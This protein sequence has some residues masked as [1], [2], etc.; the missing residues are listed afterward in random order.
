MNTQVKFTSLKTNKFIQF[1]VYSNLWISIGAALLCWQVFHLN[2]LEFNLDYFLFV[3]FSTLVS[4]TVQRLFRINKIAEFNPS[5]WVVKNKKIAITLT[6]VGLIG[7]SISLIQFIS[8]PV[9]LWLIPSGIIS[10]LYS[11][12]KLRDVPY[13]KIFLISISWGIICG[14][15]PFIIAENLDFKIILFN[16]LIIM[17]YITA[18]TIPF[19]IRDL[20]LDE[21]AKRTIP[22]MTG[23][24]NSKNVALALLGISLVIFLSIFNPI[25]SIV[26]F[27]SCIVSGFLIFNSTRK[28]SD[29]YFSFLIDGHIIFQFLLIFFLS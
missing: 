6:I 25:Q 23:V 10:L 11:L 24:P 28:K 1:I 27:I 9:I 13:L 18:I 4:Y 12:K 19:D 3:F 22:Q 17:F 14:V 16:F 15:I 20:G 8:I 26:Y 2:K 5:A 7:A 21:D 29:F